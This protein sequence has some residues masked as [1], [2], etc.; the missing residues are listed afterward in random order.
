MPGMDAGAEDWQNGGFALYVHWPFC[1]SKCPYCD[2][3][4][5]V[6]KSVDH[7]LWSNALVAQI[8]AMGRLLPGRILDSI[9]FGGG[10]PSLMEPETVHRVIAAA[11]NG[12]GTRNTLE[13]TLEA[14]PSSVEA[15]RFVA[16]RDA[17]VNRVSLGIQALD[18][19]ALRLLGR[20]HTVREALQAWDV[21]NQVFGRTS[22]DLIY[23]RQEQGLEEWRKELES[24]LALRPTHLSLY[25]LTIEDG[26]AFGERYRLGRLTNLPD[27]DLSADL[28]SL[29]Q[30]ICSSAGLPQYEISNHALPGN[31]SH[32]NCVYW[33]Y[34]DYVG[35]GPGA[36]GRITVNGQ[37]NSQVNA[38]N[39]SAWLSQM[40]D[41]RTMFGDMEPLSAEEQAREYLLMSLR[42]VEGTDLERYRRIGGTDLRPQSIDNLV[43]LGL[44]WARE[45]RIGATPDGRP[46]LNAILA[47]LIQD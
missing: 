44:L 19:R 22:F 27:D 8:E 29:T 4:S 5:Y 30:D 11:R 28:Y 34:G 47:E 14:N 24:A 17:G 26:T 25:Q 31:E 36:H 18:D 6:E 32:H 2:F 21:A 42:L 35:V 16:Y 39:P 45:K 38:R 41:E 33:R 15:G 37:R 13:V 3:N 23:A 10:T 20:L 12:W 9:F 7:A 40:R 1:E 43:D 46:L